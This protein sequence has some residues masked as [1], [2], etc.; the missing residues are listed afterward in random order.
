MGY[1]RRRA[2]VGADVL[3]CDKQSFSDE[4]ADVSRTGAV[5]SSLG[6]YPPE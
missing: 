6:F 1:C 2:K 3:I 5:T 4:S